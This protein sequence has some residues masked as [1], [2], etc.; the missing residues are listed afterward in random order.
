[1]IGIIDY[2]MG[3]L[4][5]VKNAC[6]HLGLEAAISADPEFLAGCDRLILPG[7]GAFGD[8]DAALRRSGIRDFLLE[9]AG[10]KKKP[11]L[12]ICL[13]MQALFERS[14]EFGEY[15]GLGFVQG[16]V[17]AME[18]YGVR[19]PEIGWNELVL[20]SAHPL[21]ACFDHPVFVYYDHSYC[22]MNYDPASLAG[23]SQYGPYTVC[24][25]IA[26][27]NV[28]GTQFHPEK[29]GKDGLRIL[30]WFGKE[31]MYDSASGN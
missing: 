12:G 31:F 21:S 9:E 19:I 5:S 23:Y 28:I 24:G 26:K 11:L 1:M 3:N 25:I 7:V 14:Y 29:S 6:D 18:P 27:D 30:E 2:G 22:A 17:R 20:S 10:R 15:E 16:E 4:H 13:G 8:M